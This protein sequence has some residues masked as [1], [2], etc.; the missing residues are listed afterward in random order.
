MESLE[1]RVVR[2]KNDTD[3]LNM[4]IK[5]YKPFIASIIKQKT[6]KY[7]TYGIDDELS[8]G[9][10]AFKEAIDSYQK[11]KGKFLSFAKHVIS[12]RLIDYYRKHNKEKQEVYI[13]K[14][15]KDNQEDLYDKGDVKAISLHKAKEENEIRRIEISEFKEELEKWGISFSDLVKVSPKRQK[16]VKLYKEVASVIVQNKEI[17]DSL[18]KTKRLPIKEIQKNKKIHRKKLE[19][20]RIYIIALVIV[21]NSDFRFIKSYI[22]A[23]RGVNI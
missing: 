18:I 22:G 19:R 15:N 9:M 4:L 21:M 17:L 13:Y 5:D 3:E 23:D 8:I 16:L 14:A 20:G 1:D 10:M 12:L 2:A 6:G 7:M 11:S